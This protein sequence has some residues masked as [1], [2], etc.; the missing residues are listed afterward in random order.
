M[1]RAA[2]V[3]ALFYAATLAAFETFINWGQWQWWPWW[4]VDYVS[5]GLLVAGGVFALRRSAKGPV[6]LACGW[7][8]A[9]AMMWM[10]LAGNIEAGAVPARAGRVGGLY[11]ALIAFSMIWS[12]LG[13]ALTLNA[14]S[15]PQSKL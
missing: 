12:I 11:I 14:R 1:L 3:M 6:L 10:S 13:L 4:L 5:A 7:G 8:F 9:I 15:D 2:A